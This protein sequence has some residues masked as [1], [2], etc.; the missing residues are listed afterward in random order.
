M[1]RERKPSAART[2]R[3]LI[4][5]LWARP[6]TPQ[7][8]GLQPRAPGVER[9][10]GLR[11]ARRPPHDRA[12]PPPAPPRA[13]GFRCPLAALP[14]GQRGRKRPHR[15]RR[16]RLGQ[17][18]R[19][20]PVRGQPGSRLLLERERIRR[21][22]TR[23]GRSLRRRSERASRWHQSGPRSRPRLRIH[24]LGSHRTQRS[25]R[26]PLLAAQSRCRLLCRNR[27]PDQDQGHVRIHRPGDEEA[28]PEHLRN[29]LGLLRMRRPHRRR[30]Q[31]GVRE[32]RRI[33]RRRRSQGD[34]GRRH[35][36]GIRRTDRP[37][38]S[39]WATKPRPAPNSPAG[40]S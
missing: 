23:Q 18:V 6:R 4:A 9:R 22:R 17:G 31:G 7:R 10:S 33:H 5:A 13:P 38:A 35:R 26:I 27:R 1:P 12:A 39:K 19:P 40:K 37:Q 25:K 28:Q 8:E 3:A 29:R 32:R 15:N 21:I 11:R 2:Q 30:R 24:R 14:L 36:L 16:H 34:P 20:I